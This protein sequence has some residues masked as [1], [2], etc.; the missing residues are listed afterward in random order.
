MALDRIIRAVEG[1][2]KGELG[3]A[4][5]WPLLAAGPAGPP[6]FTAGAPANSVGVR[7]R[8]KSRARFS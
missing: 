2:E 3:S 5:L 4:M 1:K 7:K 6:F 8:R